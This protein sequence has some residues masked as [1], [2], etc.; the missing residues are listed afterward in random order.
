[1]WMWTCKKGFAVSKDVIALAV[2]LAHF[3]TITSTAEESGDG[4]KIDVSSLLPP[5]QTE[6]CWV[7]LHSLGKFWRLFQVNFYPF[8][9]FF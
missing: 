1:M 3:T 2:L 7:V 5:P 4:A 6:Q 9:Q 8:S